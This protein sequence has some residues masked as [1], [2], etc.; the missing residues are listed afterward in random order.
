MQS[1]ISTLFE[2]SGL[3]AK[4]KP[5]PENIRR[6]KIRQIAEVLEQLSDIS[7]YRNIKT[8]PSVFSHVASS[9]LGG[10]KEIGLQPGC[11]PTNHRV[12][13]IKELAQFAAF[14]SD[15]VYVNEPFD[16]TIRSVN[17]GCDE[18]KVRRDFKEDIIVL[19]ELL[20]L[21]D[22]GRIEIVWFDDMCP[23]CFFER[24]LDIINTKIYTQALARLKARYEKEVKFALGRIGKDFVF[25]ATG[26]EKLLPPHGFTIRMCSNPEWL[27]KKMPRLGK[28]GEKDALLEI[29]PREARLLE[30]AENLLEPII[31]SFVFELG[32]AHHF[33][34]AYL[35]DSELEIDF[36]HTITKDPIA[37][38][39]TAL[40]TK[41]LTCIV[42]FIAGIDTVDLL[43]LRESEEEAFVV[44]RAALTNAI[45]EYKTQG[46]VLTERDAQAIYGDIIQPRLAMLDVRV[47]NAKRA[48]FKK[49][50][51]EIL[52]WT[53]SITAGLYTGLLTGNPLTGATAF[54]AAKV[55]AELVETAMTRTDVA[56]DIRNEEM[57]FLWRVKELTRSHEL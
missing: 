8:Q 54:G 44:F 48:F 41:Y 9:A 13:K 39:Q 52:G 22:S 21:L 53:A 42:P 17:S 33:R 24:S 55:G 45:N 29:T 26:S 49:S 18:N 40:M 12:L 38:R 4:G 27:I 20:P 23:H 37:L 1:T 31:E 50:M 34:T 57:Y 36:I 30:I 15:K 51:R 2:N 14:Y 56:E 25:S 3:I 7:S 11:N 19:A 16:D 10:S 46:V 43:K 28:L 47:R 35:S 5:V 6:L 32:A